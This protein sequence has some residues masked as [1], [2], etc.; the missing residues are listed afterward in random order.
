MSSAKRRRLNEVSTT[1]AKPF[2]SPLKKPVDTSRSPALENKNDLHLSESVQLT[3]SQAQN[4]PS[5]PPAT[6][7]PRTQESD[8]VFRQYH[9]RTSPIRSTIATQDAEIVALQ[10]QHSALI[11]RLG[12]LKQ[13][14]DTGQ[15]A[16][17]IESSGEDIDLKQLTVKWRTIA[18]GAA[19]EVYKSMKEQ[20]DQVG[21][22]T[23][24][25][26]QFQTPSVQS[27]HGEEETGDHGLT[28]DQKEASRYYREEAKREAEKYNLEEPEIPPD[29]DREVSSSCKVIPLSTY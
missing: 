15:Q 14:L 4:N 13:L 22:M 26:E 8:P 19:E 2:R 21:G 25:Q 23:A 20:F 28:E 5:E 1:L 27:R 12:Q 16:L 24:W 17:R 10:K 3:T 29:R 6:S 11:L 7:L 18:R 9:L